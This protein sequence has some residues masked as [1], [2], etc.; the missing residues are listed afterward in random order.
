MADEDFLGKV[1][2]IRKAAFEKAAAKIAEDDA[3]LGA[4]NW[5]GKYPFLRV[6]HATIDNEDNKRSFIRRADLPPGR[7]SVENQKSVVS[8]WTKIAETWNDLDFN[9]ATKAMPNEHTNFA[10][11]DIISH[12]LVAHMSAATVEKDELK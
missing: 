4:G 5:V 11:S 10:V 2:A 1:I 7:M 8:V 6:L 12:E 3:K 9:P